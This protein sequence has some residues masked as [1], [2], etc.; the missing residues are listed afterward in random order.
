VVSTVVARDVIKARTIRKL[1]SQIIPFVFVLLVIAGLDRI[2]IVAMALKPPTCSFASAKGP[3][4][5]DVLPWRTL[6]VRALRTG[7]SASAAM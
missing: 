1:R 2:N 5:T 4:V 3:S 6:T 7:Y